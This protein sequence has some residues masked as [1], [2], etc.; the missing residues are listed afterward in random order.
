MTAQKTID[1]HA[2]IIG[3]DTMRLMQQD[4]PKIAPRITRI[5]DES[6]VFEVAGTPYRP[7]PRGGWD[8]ERRLKDSFHFYAELAHGAPLERE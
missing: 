6:S 8:L 2:H 7:F 4:A 5:D 3:E 1:V